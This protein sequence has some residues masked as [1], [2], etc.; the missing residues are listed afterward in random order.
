MDFSDT[1]GRTLEEIELITQVELN[2]NDPDLDAFSFTIK[3][4]QVLMEVKEEQ[5]NTIM[6]EE[7]VIVRSIGRAQW[8]PHEDID[9]KIDEW[10]N[11]PSSL[12]LH[13]YLGMTEKEYATFVE[14]GVNYPTWREALDEHYLRTKK[15]PND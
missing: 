9:D 2:V 5:L 10:V 3:A 7:P 11:S 1:Q 12:P 4:L 15:V 6:L 8:E 14:R 13:I